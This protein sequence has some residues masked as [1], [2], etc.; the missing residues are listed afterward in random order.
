VLRKRVKGFTLIELL[1]VVAIIALLISILLPSLARARE[2][3]K[4]AVCRANLRGLG[5]SA[6]IYSNDYNES[7]PITNYNA[8]AGSGTDPGITF[9]GELGSDGNTNDI[10][11]PPDTDD[12]YTS[13][14]V[15]MG[16]HLFL[17]VIESG[18]SPGQFICPSSGDQKDDLRTVGS[19]Q[20]TAA[21]IGVDRFDFKS[22]GN[23]SYGYQVPY[24]LGSPSVGLDVR[25]A[26][27]A[28]KGPYYTGTNMAHAGLD[29]PL[30]GTD[31]ENDPLE[32]SNTEWTQW[33]SDN[34]GEEGQAILFVDGHVD[35][36]KTPVAGADNDNIYTY[37]EAQD[38][39]GLED[40]MIGQNNNSTEGP[41]ASTDSFIAP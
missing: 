16:R 24:G 8:G 18:S 33:N 12:G 27:M 37:H 13:D 21:N 28:D 1:V 30:T 26:L 23:L 34:H 40:I 19:G 25:M 29:A 10:D 15:S 7:F 9:I 36:E 2:L 11:V 6:Y 32:A 41:F 3:A 5:Q 38:E 17:L 14:N 39:D 31:D 4:R 20:E 22:L 35:F